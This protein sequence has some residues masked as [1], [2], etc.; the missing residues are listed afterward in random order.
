MSQTK[1]AHND[2]DEDDTDSKKP[3][4]DETFSDDGLI[5]GAPGTQSQPI[6]FQLKAEPEE[7]HENGFIQGEIKAEHMEH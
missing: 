1:S 5:Y 3:R 7:S 4:D 6:P 2:S